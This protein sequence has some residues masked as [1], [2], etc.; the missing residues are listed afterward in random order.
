MSKVPENLVPPVVGQPVS[1]DDYKLIQ[2]L[3]KQALMNTSGLGF[4]DSEGVHTQTGGAAGI[5]AQLVV[6]NPTNQEQ[7]SET[8]LVRN[9]FFDIVEDRWKADTNVY[10]VKCWPTAKREDYQML[11]HRAI[12]LDVETSVQR[13]ISYDGVSVLDPPMT[14]EAI[15]ALDFNSRIRVSDC[16]V[17][18]E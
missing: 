6:I 5:M 8:C 13:A 16:Q 1:A 14:K 11:E 17:S 15:I 7:R 9:V 3:V 18:E 4:V 10:E 2:D 12:F